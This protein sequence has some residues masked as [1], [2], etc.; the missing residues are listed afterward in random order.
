MGVGIEREL[1]VR[2]RR[3]LQDM[4][5]ERLCVGES[6]VVVLDQFS[7]TDKAVSVQA[8]QLKVL[9]LGLSLG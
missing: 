3:H 6:R 8:H 7:K 2:T 4:F 1:G 9:Y 5:S